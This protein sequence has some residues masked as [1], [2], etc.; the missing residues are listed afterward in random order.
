[1][2]YFNPPLTITKSEIDRSV[3]LFK[4]IIRAFPFGV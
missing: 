2:L 4:G 1:V 3:T